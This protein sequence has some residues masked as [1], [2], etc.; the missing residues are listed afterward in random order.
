LVLGFTATTSW[1][2][3]SEKL[4]G[5]FPRAL[6]V[7]GDIQYLANAMDQFHNRFPVYDDVS[8]A[9]NH[10][11]T[12]TRFPGPSA[13]VTID[14]SYS[15]DKHSG[16][17]SIRCTFAN[18]GDNFGGYNFQNGVLAGGATAPSPNFGTVF[19]A[20]L[21]LSGATA[22]TFWARGQNGG[23]VVDFFMG[24][25]GWNGDTVNSPCTPSF[26]GPCPASDSTPAVKITVALSNQWA[27]Y[28]INLTGRNLSY[29]LGGFGWGVD[30]AVNPNGAVFYL[31]DIQYELNATRQSQRLNEPRF[32]RSFTTLPLQPNV[33]DANRDDD[34]DVVLRNAAFIYDNA[35]AILAFLA[36]GSADSI[37]RAKL[38]GDAIVY[39]SEH[40]RTFNDGKLRSA[41]AAGD[42]AL[43]PGWTP[44]NR[45]GTAPVAGYYLE[46]PQLF[47]EASESRI[48]DTGNNAWAMIALL[49]LHRSAGDA[50]YLNTA[51]VLGNFIRSCK[52][53]VGT[54][55]GF[56]GGL[57]YVI[58]DAE[59][60]SRREYASTEH[61]L[62]VF[63]AFSLMSRLTGEAV[64]HSD[65]QHAQQFVEAMWDT[66][67][68]CYL[69]G[70]TDPDFRNTNPSQLPLDV[71]AWG[72]LAL[73]NALTLHPQV[74]E[75]A[76]SNHRA[77]QDGFNGF[78]FNNDKDG[79]WFEGTGQMAVAYGWAN[80]STA[81]ASLVEEL[82][83]AQSTPPFGDGSGI[84]AAS[85]D[86]V[87]TG[88]DFKLFRRLHVGATA[89][90]VFAQ[91][92]FN[93]YYQLTSAPACQ[94]L[95]TP[96]SQGFGATG[97]TGGINVF[98][99]SG[100]GWQAISEAVWIT[101]TSGSIGAGGSVV[102]YSVSANNGP[103]RTGTMS[104]A[105]QTVTVMQ[106]SGCPTITVN[107]GTIS[108]GTVDSTYNQALNAT[109]GTAP[110]I[111]SVA[112]GALPPGLSL[113]ANGAI[114]GAPAIN[115]TF[116]FTVSA[117]DVNGCSGSRA[118][119]IKIDGIPLVYYP[120]PFPIRL[121][122]SRPGQSAC[123]EPGVPL[124]ASGVRKVNAR[125]NCFGTL[126]PPT[127]KAVAGNATVVNF[128]SSG[129][130]YITLFPCDGTP[131][132][133]SN[134]NF[135]DN[136]IIPNF[137]IAGLCADGG[138]RIYSSAATDLII[139]VTGYFAPPGQGGLYFHPLPAPVRLLDTRP[140]ETACDTPG[141]PLATNGVKTV[142]AHRSCLGATIPQSAKAIAGNATVVNFISSG[143]HWITLYPSGALQ[144]NA[145]N[146]NFSANQIVPN[147]FVTG[148][149]NDGRFDIYSHAATDF[150]VDVTGYFSDEAVDV[151]GQGLFFNLLSKPVRLLDTRSG[152][153]ACKAPGT[154]LADEGVL[155]LTAHGGCFGET[156]PS[157]ARSIFGN[158][159]VVNFL[160]SGLHWITLYPFGGMRPNASNLNFH[161][162]Q[163]IP[164]AF[165]VGVSNDGKFN[166]YSHA[167]TD[168]IVDLTGY[169]AP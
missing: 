37:R 136:Q 112:G 25:V 72:V 148:L 90:R 85:H 28:S 36:D 152:A 51:R 98:A 168:F 59:D 57:V 74:F 130:N 60:P 32:I 116:N 88:F 147:A 89:W 104:I 110:Y 154:P 165:F 7:G 16:A 76:E 146:L 61:N 17:T 24:G 129:F 137:F 63:A 6:S 67:Q 23:E 21:D 94:Y 121:F 47:R 150:I 66:N 22:L 1:V 140:G 122:D 115:G 69:A 41:Y 166:V 8:S 50:R 103:A 135:R 27:K 169:F 19:N 9:G 157:T 18:G 93:P 14:G 15:L 70:T 161:E 65:A 113:S 133:V 2:I 20:G 62:D 5:A 99:G 34:I 156:V 78:D 97:G 132:I 119:T 77:I 73:P 124:G 33:Q 26:P 68:N 145:S 142:A 87:S 39:A 128:I 139:D 123:D 52:N 141:A 127:A 79:V 114:S 144:P 92:G 35:L 38:I 162:N 109:G 46:F 12:L 31:D 81:A 75:C 55:Q 100:C 158:A 3:Y 53:S 108:Q 64:W 126:I 151:N 163:I 125:G 48:F 106:A 10:F 167:S 56:T 155:A 29:V 143:F 149:S 96:L 102:S 4:S 83:R 13:L 117:T 134:L 43:P 86:A 42:I 91:L 71:Q 153:S 164:N 160:S 49:A 101:I 58:S 120:L 40:D 159:T 105:G 107:P 11:H 84:A 138:F 131:P 82:N 111:F 54:Y 118:Y 80:Q 44:N 30:G 45:V 95:I